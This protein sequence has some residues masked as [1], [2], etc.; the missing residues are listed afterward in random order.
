MA[1]AL[2]GA[3]PEKEMGEAEGALMA[4]GA[5]ASKEEAARAEEV[6]VVV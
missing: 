4:A 1:E 3:T 6:M 2:G 5:E